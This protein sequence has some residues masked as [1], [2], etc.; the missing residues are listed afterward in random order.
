MKQRATA[1]FS[2]LFLLAVLLPIA[3]CAANE[4]ETA[5]APALQTASSS[6]AALAE[7]IEA[8]SLADSTHY[9]VYVAY[10]LQNR[11]EYVYQSAPMRSASM[12]K[13]FILGTAMERV[14]DGSLSLSQTLVLHSS[15]KVGGAGVLAGY[16][17]GSELSLDTVMR[18]MITESDNTATNMMIDLLGMDEINAYMQRN[19]YVDT[20]LQR[21]MM[22]MEA[23][24]EGRENY[25]SAADLGHFFLRLY[26]RSCV[27]PKEDDVMLEYLAGQTDTECFPTAMP[28]VMIAHKTGELGGLYDDGGIIYDGEQPFIMVGMTESYSSRS[29]AIQTLQA[30]LRVAAANK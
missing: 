25:T 21:K 2:L 29:K 27:A 14:R 6:N 4:S 11:A 5:S 3:S 22:D 19:G 8:L 7:G 13:V 30:M 9:A 12:I 1:L 28:S 18:L 20:K 26:N 23:I 16:A 17:S 10:P 24:S 15:D